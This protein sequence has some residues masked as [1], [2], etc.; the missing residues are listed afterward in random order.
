MADNDWQLSDTERYLL[1]LRGYLVRQQVLSSAEV[2]ALRA[3]VDSAAPGP[4]TF[5]PPWDAA[6]CR[7]LVTHPAAVRPMEW[8]CGG[9][10]LRLDHAYGIS[11]TRQ[12]PRPLDLH[13]SGGFSADTYFWHPSGRVVGGTC[14]AEWVLTDQAGVGG[15]HCLPGS[16]KANLPVPHGLSPEHAEEVPLYA[17][18]L[19]IFTEA[20][21]H[22]S[23]AWRGDRM[24]QVLLL[25][26]SPG[27]VAYG[28]PDQ[29]A[30]Q[31]GP[32][33]V[34]DEALRV[35]IEPPFWYGRWP[36]TY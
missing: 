30:E 27:S 19:L 6:E 15:F 20:L 17:G 14:V 23:A 13:G 28:R 5:V 12:D 21:L 18:D 26:Y 16:H 35:L 9:G 8:L 31:L 22:G 32:Y 29:I 1:D 3:A 34:E 10:H 2:D 25:K 36:G 7:R 4:G 11:A 33:A 24:R